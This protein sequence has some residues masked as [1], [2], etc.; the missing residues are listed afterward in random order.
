MSKRQRQTARHHKQELRRQ[1]QGHVFR[2]RAV[3][4]AT[5]LLICLGLAGVCISFLGHGSTIRVEPCG[6]EPGPLWWD[7]SGLTG[8]V[9]A[10]NVGNR[11][12]AGCRQ[13]SHGVTDGRHRR[14]A[15]IGTNLSKEEQGGIIGSGS[16]SSTL[17]AIRSAWVRQR[18]Q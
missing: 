18:R 15:S 9:W 1:A 11:P 4:K 6:K 12:I 3:L 8:W 17:T 14:A 10:C 16:W 2:T 5:T 7:H 13:V